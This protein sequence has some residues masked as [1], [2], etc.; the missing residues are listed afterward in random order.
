MLLKF[1]P[2]LKIPAIFQDRKVVLQI[3]IPSLLISPDLR[4][5]PVP[6]LL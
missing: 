5:Y 6:D 4:F 1:F 2:H 3:R